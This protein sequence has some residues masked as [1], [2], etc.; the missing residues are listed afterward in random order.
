MA[1]IRGLF[2]FNGVLH[3]VI[4]D[5]LLRIDSAGNSAVLG[6]LASGA[7]PVDFEQ[8]LTQLVFTDGYELY[9]WDGL[10][11]TTT[12]NWTAGARIAFVDQRIVGI[13]RASQRFQWTGLGD[14]RSAAAL[15]FASAE[16][17]PDGLVSILATQR[18]LLLLGEYTGE[19]WYSSG[20]T[21]VFQRAQSEFL[22]VGCVAAFSAQMVG[23]T[24][25]WLARDRRGQAQVVAG[26]GQ[27]ISTR[28]IEER[29]EDRD[30]ARA[31][32]YSYSDG[33]QHFYCLN[34]VGIDT[35]LVYDTTFQQ[36]HERAE[37]VNGEYQPWRP[38][39]HAF[40]YGRHYFGTE[41]GSI[42]ELD[43]DANTF[44][45]DTKCRDRIAPVISEPSRKRL[46]FP[47]VEV[48]CEKAAAKKILLRWSDDN[49]ATWS[50][51]HEASNGD[52]GKYSQRVRWN[53]TGSA[54]DRVYQ[55]RMTDDAPF[56]PIGVDV[57]IA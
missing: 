11:L 48:V 44:A 12:A 55:M 50:N 15:D 35:T 8:T 1:Q 19:V 21:S 31:R 9:V 25:I 7:G 26:R 53:R 30:L 40:A 47:S 13:Q 22:Q 43:R 51:W 54:F 38:T 17:A 28:A 37:L 20:G 52:I 4:D 27:R 49:G 46:R 34:V 33:G 24:P 41:D 10:T 56:N 16:G 36:W 3:A 14:A 18:E 42:Y 32:A 23:D 6:S 2:T 29:F 57:E 45:G 5:S 39:C